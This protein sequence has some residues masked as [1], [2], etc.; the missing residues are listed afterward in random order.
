MARRR[1]LR[2]LSGPLLDRVDLQIGVRPVTRAAIRRVGLGE[3]TAVVATRVAQARTTARQRLS[4]TPWRCNADVPGTELAQ[5]VMRLG[6][7]ATQ[8]LD[9]AMERGTL[10]VRGLHRVLRV[11]WTIAD[12]GGLAVPSRNEVAQAVE[13][14]HHAVMA[15]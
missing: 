10:T 1:Y 5:G 14:R 7:R 8:D 6:Q 4:S 2:R 13:L 3:S 15:A 11:A 9:R 12:L